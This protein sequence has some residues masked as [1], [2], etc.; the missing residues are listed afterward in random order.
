MRHATRLDRADEHGVTLRAMLELRASQGD[1]SSIRDLT[2]PEYP[3]S[4]EYL[5]RWSQELVGRSG[6]GQFAAA[7]LSWPSLDAWARRTGRDPSYE[8]QMA[9]MELDT[10]MR[11]PEEPEEQVVTDVTQPKTAVV[12]PWPS[13]K[14]G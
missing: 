11:N 10:A 5:L 3:E 8:E 13:K 14:S 12:K 9:L 4:V 2:P 6:M 1:A 7:P